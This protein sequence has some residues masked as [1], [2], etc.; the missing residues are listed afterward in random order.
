MSRSI[1]RRRATALTVALVLAALATL[2]Y[3]RYGG[4]QSAPDRTGPPILPESALEVAAQ[5]PEPIGNIAVSAGGRLF[6]TVHPESRPSGAKLL[7]WRDG[8]ARPYPDAA[9]QSELQT[10][11]G[12][13]I[14]A[15]ER[16]WVIDHGLHGLGAVQLR[17]YALADGTTVASIALNEVAPAGSFLQDLRISPDGRHAVIADVSFW[18]H[19]PALVIVDLEQGRAWRT[20]QQDPSVMP[21]DWQIRTPAK[22]MAFFGGLVWLKPGVDGVA[23]SDDGRWVYYAAMAHDRLYRVPLAQLTDPAATEAQRRAAV[24]AVA[25]KPM[26]DGLSIDHQGQVLITDVEHGAVLRWR[27]GQPAADTLLQSQRIR[28]A[29][30]FSHGPEDWLYL[31]DS[32]IPEQMLRSKTHIAAQGPYTIWRFRSGSPGRPGQ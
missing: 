18:R 9:R 1:R 13:T 11:L 7:E 14:D 32:A 6:F 27:P 5:Y 16:L 10:P 28:W 20:L 29:D 12:L 24:E 4:G 19:Q 17:G 21:Q 3:A 22:P 2:L 25:A 23:I 30:G 26:S 8:A 31:A 15:R